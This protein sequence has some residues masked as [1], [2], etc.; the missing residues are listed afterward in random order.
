MITDPAR[1]GIGDPLINVTDGLVFHKF[2]GLCQKKLTRT[3]WGP[4]PRGPIESGSSRVKAK[5]DRPQDLP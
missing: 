3:G 2:Q 1:G 4:E 5:V